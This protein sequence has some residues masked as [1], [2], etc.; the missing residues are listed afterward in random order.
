MFD[1]F[2]SRD[3]AVRI[4]LTALLSLVAL[5]MVTYLIPGYGGSGGTS[6]GDN[7]V[8]EI[9]KQ[10]VTVRD[11]QMAVRAATRNRDLPPAMMAHYVPQMIDQMINEKAMI[12]QAVRMG[13]EVTEADTAKAI[14]EQM[15]HLFP[16]GAF[17]G[18]EAYAAALAQQDMSIGEFEAYMQEQRQAA[19]ATRQ[20]VE[21]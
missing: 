17:V 6:A 9:G 4:F 13:L 12:Y 10:K 2:R 19:A 21:S 16:N 11:V 3:K 20:W 15:P 8:A 5:S 1:L 18:K 14:R 7:V